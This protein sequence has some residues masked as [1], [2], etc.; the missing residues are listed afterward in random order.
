MDDVGTGRYPLRVAGTDQLRLT[1][2]HHVASRSARYKRQSQNRDADGRV[3]RAP[4]PGLGLPARLRRASGTD[5][6]D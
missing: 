4:L 3:R 2:S 6:P 5:R 1:L